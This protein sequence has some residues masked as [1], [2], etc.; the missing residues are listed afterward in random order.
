M[1]NCTQIKASL[2][3][4]NLLSSGILIGII[5]PRI[6]FLEIVINWFKLDTELVNF[7]LGFQVLL[8]K[9]ILNFKFSKSHA[10]GTSAQN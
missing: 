9:P 8:Q 5:S 10:A 4:N 6:K 3:W 2:T 7:Y 1:I